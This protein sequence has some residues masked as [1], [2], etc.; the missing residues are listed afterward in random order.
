[1]TE[2]EIL[3]M[4]NTL[5]VDLPTLV[6]RVGLVLTQVLVLVLPVLPVLNRL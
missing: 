5:K 1:M 3:P 2:K 4:N 6:L